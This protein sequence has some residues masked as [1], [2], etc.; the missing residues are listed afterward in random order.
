MLMARTAERSLFLEFFTAGY[1]RALASGEPS[2]F[3]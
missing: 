3:R 2:E 1:R